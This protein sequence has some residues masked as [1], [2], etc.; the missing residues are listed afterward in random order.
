LSGPAHFDYSAGAAV[1]SRHPAFAN[2]ALIP[3]AKTHP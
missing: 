3:P 1:V 2:L